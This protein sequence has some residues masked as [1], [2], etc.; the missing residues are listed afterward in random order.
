M[1]LQDLKD[2]RA[3]IIETIITELDETMV[4]EVMQKM[5]DMLGFNGIRS[6]NAVDYVREVIYLCNIEVKQPVNTLWGHGCKYSTQA[7]YQ[8]S[9]L[10]KKWN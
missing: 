9:C 6:K 1:T 3:E 8:R 5:V 2:N 7:E 4:K 10:G